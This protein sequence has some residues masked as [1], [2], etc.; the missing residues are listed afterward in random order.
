MGSMK[1]KRKAWMQVCFVILSAALLLLFWLVPFIGQK[2][3]S[4]TENRSLARLPA[5]S[6]AAF[7]DGGYQDNLENAAGDQLVF[8]E[9][10]RSAVKEIQASLLMAEQDLLCLVNPSLRNGYNQIAD[11]YYIYQHDE[12]RIIEKPLDYEQ[13]ARDISAFAEPFN[14]LE[15]VRRYLYFIN[16]SR[17]MDF[18]HPESFSSVYDRVCSFFTLDGAACFTSEDYEDY[19]RWF[20]QTDHHWNDEGFYRGYREIVSL[21]KPEDNPVG[22]GE[23]LTTDAVFNGS[24]ARVTKSLRADE[25]FVVRTFDLPKHTVMLNGKR[26]NYGRQKAYQSGRFSAEPLTNHY[27]NCYGGDYGE[28]V[29]DFGTKG[30]GRLLLIASSYSNPINGLI[31]SHFDETRVIDLRYYKAYAGCDFDPADYVRE[32]NI[33]TVLLLGD[34]R[35]FLPDAAAEEGDC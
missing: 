20:Y 29:Y 2:D 16:N 10:L 13:N 25:R 27:A 30:R 32:H 3:I 6:A 23:R 26:G 19:C 8:S 17:S 14:R 9:E 31:A 15:G 22:P 33:D 18:D 35:L 34:I 4:E 12:H 24:Y 28:I 21:L 11:G 1:K 5:F 7:L